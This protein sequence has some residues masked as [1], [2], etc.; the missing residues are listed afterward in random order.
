MQGAYQAD[1]A[2]LCPHILPPLLITQVANLPRRRRNGTEPSLAQFQST[3]AACPWPLCGQPKGD[4]MWLA[5]Q[6]LVLTLCETSRRLWSPTAQRGPSPNSRPH[7]HQHHRQGPRGS[8]RLRPK[9]HHRGPIMRLMQASR[10]LHP[11]PPLDRLGYHRPALAQL[12]SG[13][14][15]P[16]FIH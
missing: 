16:Q 8:E 15:K 2:L 7:R 9:G 10:V 6:L 13:N 14:L 5:L 12:D 4:Q 11:Q 1:L 3:Q